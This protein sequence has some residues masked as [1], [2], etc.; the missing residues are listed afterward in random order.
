M[1]AGHRT[2]TIRLPRRTAL[3]AALS[4]GLQRIARAQGNYPDRP[5]RMI[6]PFPA[7]GGTD[8]VARVLAEPMRAALGQPV[9]IENRSGAGGQIGA[10]AA[11][12]A[13]PDGYT[14][15]LCTAGEVAIAPHIYGDR[16]SYDPM[17]EL[18]PITLVARVPTL[19]AVGMNVPARNTAELLAL[20][21]SRPNEV[22]CATA[23][24]LHRLN[25]ELLHRLSGAEIL[26]VTYRG[27]G[28]ALTDVIGG[29]VTM[30]FT[31]VPGMLPLVREG[32]LRPIGVSSRR[33]MA[34]QPDVPALAEH[35]QLTDYELTNWYGLFAPAGTP[36]PALDRL[37]AATARALADSEVIQRLTEQGAEAAAMPQPAFR[38]FFAAES[39]R[40]GDMVRAAGLRPEG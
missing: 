26:N 27:T 20:A 9:V 34:S 23:G 19:L 12:K 30:A 29:R 8:I 1:I 3:A 22:S 15:L 37:H 6:V 11:A 13:Q 33:R 38:E 4:A 39:V 25:A 10:Q 14:I 32:R 2:D 40:L 7:A 16:L 35:P 24:Y 28:P 21:R 18:V 17:R 36:Q 31:G 5:V